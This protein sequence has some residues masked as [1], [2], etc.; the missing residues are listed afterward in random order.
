MSYVKCTAFILCFTGIAL[1]LFCSEKLKNVH[2]GIETMNDKKESKHPTSAQSHSKPQEPKPPYPYSQEEV[3]YE[4]SSAHITL[5][6]TLTL[7]QSQ[8]PFPAVVLVHGMGPQDRDYTMMGHKLFLLLADHFTRN[9]IAV[10]R[11][12]KRGIGQSGGTFSSAV[13]SKDL[14]T[15]VV[16]GIDYL[17]TRADITIKKIG[18]IGHSE[19]GLIASMVT[20]DSSDIA[21]LVLMAG[22][23][24]TAVAAIVEQ[25]GMQ[26]RADGAS[27]ELVA[28]DAVIRKQI[29]SIVIQEADSLKAEKQIRGTIELFLEGL[30]E[31]QAHDYGKF[32]FGISKAKIEHII[33]MFNSP[34]YRYWLSYNPLTALSKITVPVLGLTGDHDFI[35]TSKLGNPLLSSAL[36]KAGNRDYTVLEIPNANHWLQTCKTG[37]F[38]EYGTIQETIAPEVV[39]LINDWV[40]ARTLKE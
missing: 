5:A 11:Y 8:G 2:K 24:T 16:A 38:A 20:A 15:D 6:G 32:V 37:A 1:A 34:F 12:D 18:L 4:N 30:T 27:E 21:F 31:K 40:V 14:A 17:K 3:R 10:L 19:G 22:A 36:K 39:T 13:T 35:V 7:P 33:K 25:A 29:L 28:L 26:L 23:V 9:G